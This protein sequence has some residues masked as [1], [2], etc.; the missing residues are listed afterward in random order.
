[1]QHRATLE[2]EARNDELAKKVAEATAAQISAQ[3][4]ADIDVLKQR[5]P[6]PSALAQQAALDVKYVRDR[7]KPPA[8]SVLQSVY[9]GLSVYD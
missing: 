4:L 3:L 6:S 7:Q 8:S 5:L 1:M 2:A 9:S